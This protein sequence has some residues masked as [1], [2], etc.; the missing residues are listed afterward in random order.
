M[1]PKSAPIHPISFL[2]LAVYIGLQLAALKFHEPWPDELQAWLIARDANLWEILF[3]ITR[4]ESTPGLWH[5]LLWLPAHLERDPI[6]VNLI[7]SIVASISVALIIFKSPFPAWFRYLV[8]FTYFLGYQYSIVARN[9]CVATL[10]MVLVSM[11]YRR[12]WER[13]WPYTLS[14]LMLAHSAAHGFL[15]AGLFA[16][17]D[18]YPLDRDARDKKAPLLRLT[19]VFLLGM[20]F[21]LVQLFPRPA[22]Y[23]FQTK[24]AFVNRFGVSLDNAFAD[25]YWL[26]ALI[27]AVSLYS[28]ARAG[29]L[30][31]FLVSSLTLGYFF[32]AWYYRPYHSGF[33]F[34]IWLFCVWQCWEPTIRQRG[35]LEKPIR[36][37]M[38]TLLLVQLYHTA[39]TVNRDYHERY[40]GLQDAV[41]DIARRGIPVDQLTLSAFYAVTAN[42]YLPVNRPGYYLWSQGSLEKGLKDFFG[43]PTRYLLAGTAKRDDIEMLPDLE[44]LGTKVVQVYPGVTLWKG[45]NLELS[46]FAL[47]ERVGNQAPLPD[48]REQGTEGR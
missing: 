34:L 28:F 26:T 14:L 27:A 19:P 45:R 29:V 33:L 38:A 46:Y 25:N 4:Y 42:A 30:Y 3:H 44:R 36:L 39:L 31:H 15:V 20:V 18:L 21:A 8:P 13:P 41:H 22:D 32:S 16:A 2:V 35:G 37:G 43:M 7:G 12:R 9:Y 48:R 23:A 10:A 1:T 40:T 6:L 47:L 11:S 5:L 17:F 24:T